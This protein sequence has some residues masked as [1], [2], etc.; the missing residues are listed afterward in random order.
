MTVTIYTIGGRTDEISKLNWPSKRGGGD[1]SPGPP[2]D[3]TN[4]NY[5]WTYQKPSYCISHQ[6]VLG[7]AEEIA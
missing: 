7:T 6:L 2:D 5:Y 3:N 1:I 4:T